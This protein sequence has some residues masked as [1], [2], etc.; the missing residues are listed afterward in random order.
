MPFESNIEPLKMA[1]CA[2]MSVLEGEGE[3]EREF[4]YKGSFI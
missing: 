4:N 1:F 2:C 3:K